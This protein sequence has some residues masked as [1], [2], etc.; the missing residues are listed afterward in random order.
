[1]SCESQKIAGAEAV[2][3]VEGDMCGDVMRGAVEFLPRPRVLHP[4]PS[5]RVAV[6]HPGW[7]PYA[8]KPHVPICAGGAR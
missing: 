4:W 8:G 6:K 5:E 3:N 7:E 2:S 1:L